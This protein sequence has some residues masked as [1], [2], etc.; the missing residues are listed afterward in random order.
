MPIS[1]PMVSVIVP[2]YNAEQWLEAACK[3]LIS[4]SYANWE[5]VLVVDGSPDDSITVARDMAGLDKDSSSLTEKTGGS[6]LLA[7]Q[8]WMRQAAITFFSSL[9]SDDELYPNALATLMAASRR[10]GAEIT[11]GSGQDLFPDGRRKTYWTQRS[12][13]FARHRTTYQLREMPSILDDHVV[14]AK[15]Y[16]RSLFQR[17]GVRFPEGVHCEDIIF[18]L[19]CQ[20]AANKIAI[21]NASYLS[22]PTTRPCCER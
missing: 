1:N 19:T 17:T 12:E 22:S 7:T 14:W 15:L 20:L 6:A 18:A 3:S 10:S 5:A 16:D 2:V 4:Q 13:A 8:A 11:A 21:T 9:D